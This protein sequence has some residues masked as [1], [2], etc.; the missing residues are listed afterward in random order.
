MRLDI[1]DR[2]YQTKGI[3]SDPRTTE[4]DSSNSVKKK[5]NIEN[6]TICPINEHLS[7]MYVKKKRRKN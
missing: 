2:F 7:C 3:L 1:K 5:K 6:R 4:E